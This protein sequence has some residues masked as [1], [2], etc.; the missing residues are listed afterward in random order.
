MVDFN[1]SIAL[2]EGYNGRRDLIWSSNHKLHHPFNKALNKKN[3]VN[4]VIY[5]DHIRFVFSLEENYNYYLQLWNRWDANSNPE[6]L[7]EER[8]CQILTDFWEYFLVVL[9]IKVVL[10]L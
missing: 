10:K 8:L 4:K 6:T 1:K 7:K 2:S 3:F 9:F 5:V